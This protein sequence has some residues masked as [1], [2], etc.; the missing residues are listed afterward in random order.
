MFRFS[1]TWERFLIALGEYPIGGEH[2]LADVFQGS[3]SC[4]KFARLFA[5]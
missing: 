2:R 5:G 4:D 3:A 1:E